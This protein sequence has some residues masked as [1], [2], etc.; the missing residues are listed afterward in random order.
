MGSVLP[1]GEPSAAY[2]EPFTLTYVVA[3]S[4]GIGAN[5]VRLG[6]RVIQME[7]AASTISKTFSAPNKGIVLDVYLSNDQLGGAKVMDANGM[8]FALHAVSG[9]HAF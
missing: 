1:A 4:V 3:W 2:D 6:Q 5:S 7:N 9:R 8:I